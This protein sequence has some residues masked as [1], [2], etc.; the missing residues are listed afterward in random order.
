MDELEAHTA[1]LGNTLIAALLY[2]LEGKPGSVT[3]PNKILDKASGASG[4]GWKV[5]PKELKSG[6]KLTVTEEVQDNGK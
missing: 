5:Q 4:L 2:I 1:R 3:I 6:L